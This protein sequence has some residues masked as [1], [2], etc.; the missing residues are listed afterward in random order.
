M[1]RSS[2]RQMA[3]A[4]GL[5]VAIARCS[6]LNRISCVFRRTSRP[7]RTSFRGS[8]GGCSD[9]TGED[10]GRPSQSVAARAASAAGDLPADRRSA[11]RADEV[12]SGRAAPPIRPAPRVEWPSGPS[13]PSGL[14]VPAPREH[15]R[16][17]SGAR[18]GRSR[19]RLRAKARAQQQRDRRRGHRGEFACLRK[20]RA[21]RLILQLRVSTRVLGSVRPV[22]QCWLFRHGHP[23]P[24]QQES[25][26]PPTECYL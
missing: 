15:P 7:R 19:K 16:P 22:Y 18:S 24:A 5:S 21:P 10:S 23:S 11:A 13:G 26:F 2:A 25:P 9:L 17:P 4:V 6:G 14:L 8:S 20:E 12:R 1:P 3:A